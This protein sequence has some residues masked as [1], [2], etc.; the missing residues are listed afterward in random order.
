MLLLRE[1]T[2]TVYDLPVGSAVLFAAA[3]AA[4]VHLFPL[5]VKHVA[6]VVTDLVF[7]FA[8]IVQFRVTS[9]VGD[10]LVHLSCLGRKR[11]PA[12][13]HVLRGRRSFA[14]RMATKYDELELFARQQ[15]T[16]SVATV[17]SIYATSR[18]RA[19]LEAI[20]RL[21]DMPVSW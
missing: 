21:L 17:A 7:L 10:E 2:R 12:R 6:F 1:H 5:T 3:M 9:R 4:T 16:T 13:K 8:T 20:A 15:D 19:K 14:G 11:W 18:S